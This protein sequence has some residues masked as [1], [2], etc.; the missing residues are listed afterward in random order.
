VIDRL[1]AKTD[2]EIAERVR[3]ADKQAEQRKHMAEMMERTMRDL[4]R[5]QP[6]TGPQ[7]SLGPVGGIAFYRPRYAAPRD[8]IIP[9]EES[10]KMLDAYVRKWTDS[11]SK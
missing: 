7:P 10:R 3:R 6:M 11:L 5:S 8:P 9:P 1:A 4:V 2:P